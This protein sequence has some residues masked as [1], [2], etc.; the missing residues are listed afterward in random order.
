MAQEAVLKGV[1]YSEFRRLLASNKSF[2]FTDVKIGDTA[3]SIKVRVR[4]GRHSG[5]AQQDSGFLC[6]GAGCEVPVA[7]IQSGAILRAE[8]SGGEGCG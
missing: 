8:G 2:N 5:G 3:L 7:N 4:R 6:D 1:A